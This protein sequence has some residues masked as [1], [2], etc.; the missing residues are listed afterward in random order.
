MLTETRLNN[1]LDHPHLAD[2]SEITSMVAM[3]LNNYDSLV[4]DLEDDLVQCTSFKDLDIDYCRKSVYLVAKYDV[5]LSEANMGAEYPF[6]D[7]FMMHTLRGKGQSIS[8]G[9]RFDADEILATPEELFE[10]DPIYQQYIEDEE[11]DAD[12]PEG[13]DLDSFYEDVYAD[14]LF[15]Y[16]DVFVES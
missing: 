9:Q 15:E 14:T 7:D 4:G 16:F 13:F 8:K 5:D 2:A 6:N 12:L 1:L 11:G 3:I 10:E